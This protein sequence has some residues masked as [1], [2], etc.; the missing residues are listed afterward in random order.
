[1]IHVGQQ[2]ALGLQALDPFHGQ[3]EMGMGRVGL[4]AQAI[5]DP[6]IEPFEDGEGGLVQTTTSVE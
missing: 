3:I 5:H 2:G 4:E 1:M 6:E